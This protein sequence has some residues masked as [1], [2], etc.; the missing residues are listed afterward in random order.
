MSLH[1]QDD[2]ALR[3]AQEERLREVWKPPSGLFLRWTDT[4]NN[5]V[6]VWYTL[7]AFGF[8]LFAG[9]LALIM[10]TQLAV[11]RAV[12]EV[13]TYVIASA[14]LLMQFE[15]V[16]NVGVSLLASAGIAGLVIGLAA[17]QF[18]DVRHLLTPAARSPQMQ[19]ARIANPPAQSRPQVVPVS[20]T[21]VS[22]E[23]LFFGGD[24]ARMSGRLEMLKSIDDITPRA[25]DLDGPR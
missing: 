2:P 18:F 7:T 23:T 13:A 16:R 1:A 9:V 22:D 11:L 15:V 21:S 12:F 4:N 3:A 17:G 25:R 6:G 10:R 19:S 8:M 20:A 24:T 5:R 14:L